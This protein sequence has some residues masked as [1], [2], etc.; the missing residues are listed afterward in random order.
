MASEGN[1]TVEIPPL[2]AVAYLKTPRPWAD[3]FALADITLTTKPLAA[4]SGDLPFDAGVHVVLLELDEL[5]DDEKSLICDVARNRNCA[6]VGLTDATAYQD[7]LWV[8]SG[9][10]AIAPATT[11]TGGIT[12]SIRSAYVQCHEKRR[13]A[14][15]LRELEE[16][17][18]QKELIARAKSIMADHGKTSES[19]ALKQLRNESRKQRRSMWELAQ[20]IIDAHTIMCPKPHQRPGTTDMIGQG[21][22]AG[23]DPED[24]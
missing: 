19:E 15:Q 9:L 7:L 17:M 22:A 4:L 21:A 8:G 2:T 14:L 13:F 11:T 20:L 23:D 12:W 5:T 10:D 18:R 24:Y 6:A 16:K 1:S 3:Q